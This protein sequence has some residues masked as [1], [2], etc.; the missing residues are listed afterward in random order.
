MTKARL[1]NLCGWRSGGLL[2]D[3]NGMRQTDKQKQIYLNVFQHKVNSGVK[4]GRRHGMVRNTVN[5]K[6]TA[7][8]FVDAI[9][10]FGRISSHY[11]GMFR[12]WTQN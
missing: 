10:L 4:G 7:D 6:E 2:N 8:S 5:I 9:G 11:H 12:M 3:C 1:Y